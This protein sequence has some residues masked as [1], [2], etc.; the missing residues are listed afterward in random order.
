MNKALIFDLDGTLLNSKKEVT[1]G[2]IETLSKL[3]TI[4][5][6]VIVATA[7]PPRYSDFV[8]ESLPFDIDMIYY[9]GG[10]YRKGENYIS[11][12]IPN[13]INK[14][15]LKYIVKH[16]P[17]AN[18]S[19]EREDKWITHDYFDYESHFNIPKGPEIVDFDIMLQSS[20]TKILILNPVNGNDIK[21]KFAHLCN[22]SIT[23]GGELIQINEKNTSKASAI[24]DLVTYYDI[25]MKNVT[26]FGDDHNDIEMFLACGTSVAMGNAVNELKYIATHITETNDND[27]VRKYLDTIL[28]KELVLE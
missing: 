17:N 26:C 19:S 13:I 5:Y 24:R 27:G 16:E 15:I 18:L 11:T 21:N 22:I 6:K 9:N 8:P 23:D 28:E 20:P 25:E 7:R 10:Y 12:T 14:K 1:K 2:T 3:I 4:G